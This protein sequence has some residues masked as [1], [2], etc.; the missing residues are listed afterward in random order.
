MFG[1]TY[2]DYAELAA[3]NYYDQL[4]VDYGFN[5]IS[6]LEAR[7]LAIAYEEALPWYDEDSLQRFFALLEE[8]KFHKMFR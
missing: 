7:Q 1:L 3:F 4:L 5:K 8:A 6:Y 2:E